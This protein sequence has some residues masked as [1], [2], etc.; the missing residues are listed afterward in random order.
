MV[1][2]IL[3]P[4]FLLCRQPPPR[5]VL[6]TS[7]L[8]KCRE[9]VLWV[10]F[11]TRTL[12]LLYQGL[13]FMTSFNT[14]YLLHFILLFSKYSHTGGQGFNICIWGDANTQFIT[15]HKHIDRKKKTSF[16]GMEIFLTSD[17]S[18]T[19]I[20]RGSGIL[21]LLSIQRKRE[22]EKEKEVVGQFCP[23]RMEMQLED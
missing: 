20:P 21:C 4:L 11:L 22:R 5:F 16:E 2:F 7:F 12:I 10:S 17:F 19:Q 18:A 15:A 9:R 3:R 23:C 13:T 8:C 6:M 1:S 14:N